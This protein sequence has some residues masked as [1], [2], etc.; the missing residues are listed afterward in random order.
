MLA[1]YLLSINNIL[2]TFFFLPILRHYYILLYLTEFLTKF[3]KFQSNMQ[4]ALAEITQICE[5][6]LMTS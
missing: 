4:F 2:Q 5:K 6:T 3:K 1:E